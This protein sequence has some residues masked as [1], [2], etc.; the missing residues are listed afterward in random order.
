MTITPSTASFSRALPRYYLGA[1]AW[2]VGA[3]CTGGLH[4]ELVDVSS[5]I[6]AQTSLFITNGRNKS[7]G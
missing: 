4:L 6:D 3:I 7:Q 5:T 1:S 2:V